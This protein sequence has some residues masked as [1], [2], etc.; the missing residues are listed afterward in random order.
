MFNDSLWPPF[1]ICYVKLSSLPP[2]FPLSLSRLP[3]TVGP[4]NKWSQ[5]Q[6]CKVVITTVNLWRHIRTQH[7]P[8][9]PRDC[10]HCSKQF[11]NKYSLREHVRIAH[12]AKTTML[13]TE[14]EIL[15]TVAAASPSPTSTIIKTAPTGLSAK[16]D[17]SMPPPATLAANAVSIVTATSTNAPPSMSTTAAAATPP[18][19]STIVLKLPSLF[20]D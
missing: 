9:P 7:T 11:K 6:F 19:G 2:L 20:K 15:A 10:D 17:L 12:E 13:M 14:A 3:N 8:Q 1:A 18:V 5:C 16:P 4:L